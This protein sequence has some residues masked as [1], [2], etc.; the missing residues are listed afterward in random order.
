MSFKLRWSHFRSVHFDEPLIQCGE[1]IAVIARIA[2]IYPAS[3]QGASH[4]RAYERRPDSP[5]PVQQE[6]DE[7]LYDDDDGSATIIAPY[8]PTVFANHAARIGEEETGIAHLKARVDRLEQTLN[9][10]VNQFAVM[11]ELVVNANITRSNVA[12]SSQEPP[13]STRPPPYSR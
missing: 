8:Q 5:F 1:H 2:H 7:E 12:S 3:L 10:L 11:L 4:G 13:S 6:E 9:T